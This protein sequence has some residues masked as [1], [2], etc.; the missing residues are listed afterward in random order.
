MGK[1]QEA[2][3]ET[4]KNIV[5]TVKSILEEKSAQD[6]NIEDITTKAGVA[7]GSFYTYFKRKEDVISEIVLTEFERAKDIV[8][9]SSDSAYEQ[10]CM[11]LKQSVDIIEKN[12][13]QVAQQWMKSV[14]APLQEEKSGEKK[15]QFDIDNIDAILTKA[16]NTGELR[17]DTPIEILTENIVN[18]YYG[19][20]VAWCITK[21]D[22]GKLK[23]SLNH[24][25][26]YELTVIIELYKKT[27]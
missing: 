18:Y 15:Y 20:V 24:F 26:R 21:G 11:Y 23:E 7:K 27:K 8:T 19:A 2:A 1:R 13:L 6:I 17:A 10:I 14:I 9:K 5:E 12:T 16:V 4:R 3:L 22:E 25:C